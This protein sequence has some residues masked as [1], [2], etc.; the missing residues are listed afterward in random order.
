MLL[1]FF[2]VCISSFLAFLSFCP[3]AFVG[4]LLLSNY[5][6]FMSYRF[7]LTITDFYGTLHLALGLVGMHW[8]AAV[9]MWTVTKF[10]YSSFGVR[11]S[12]IFCKTLNL[13]LT[14]TVSCLGFMAYQPLLV[15]L[16]RIYFYTNNQYYFKHF[17]L[18]WVRSFNAKNSSISNNSV[19]HKYAV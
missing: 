10:S 4:L 3:L 15:I 14:V 5:V 7:F 1:I 13:F 17:S 12:D 19:L 9:S 18:A 6:V 2:L 11:V 16:C 8:A